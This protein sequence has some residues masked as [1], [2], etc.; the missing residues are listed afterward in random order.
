MLLE[1][2]RAL[3]EKENLRLDTRNAV[4]LLYGEIQSALEKG[5]SLEELAEMLTSSGWIITESSLRY[6]CKLCRHNNIKNNKSSKS[7]NV[8]GRKEAPSKATPEHLEESLH[9]KSEEGTSE[10]KH[11]T[12]AVEKL[13][14]PASQTK[15]RKRAPEKEATTLSEDGNKERKDAHFELPPDTEDL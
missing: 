6:Y 5:Y 13:T 14:E 9:G 12:E 4:A 15:S 10:Q 11:A 7:K 2:M 8:K 3:P 1:H